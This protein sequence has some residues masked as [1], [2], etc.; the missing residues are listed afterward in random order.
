MS[1]DTSAFDQLEREFEDRCKQ[2]QERTL[3]AGQE[4]IPGLKEKVFREFGEY[5]QKEVTRL[6]K[7]AVKQFYDSYDPDFYPR[8]RS[9]YN[10]LNLEPDEYGIIDEQIDSDSLFSAEGVT[11]FERGGGS[12]GLYE[13]VVMEG[14]H[15]GATG[16]DKRVKTREVPS[17]RAPY[18]RYSRWGHVAFRTMPPHDLAMNSIRKHETVMDSEYESIA[19]KH[20]AEINEKWQ[21]KADEIAAEIFSDWRW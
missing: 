9:L 4:M 2:W 18:D 6:F 3:A 11:P 15:G 13:H 16:T 20:C 8:S 21:K 19:T 5:Q 1:V 12:Q 10:A 17:Y 7:E 14:W